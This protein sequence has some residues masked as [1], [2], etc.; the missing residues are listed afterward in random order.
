MTI[1][2]IYVDG[3]AINNENPNVPTLGGVGIGVWVQGQEGTHVYWNVHNDEVNDLVVT[4]P[5]GNIEVPVNLALGVTTNNTTEL[6][7]IYGALEMIRLSNWEKQ[8]DTY[9][10]HGD[11]EYAGKLVF[12]T[13]RAKANK[14]LVAK[15]K[16]LLNDVRELGI[17]VTWKH[18]RAHADNQYNNYVDYLAKS[19]AYNVP[20]TEILTFSQFDNP[21]AA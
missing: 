7:A 14:E 10:I 6:A 2:N 17:D 3:S 13:W 19:G 21:I 9:I 8:N 1:V 16:S 20:P 5:N 12:G 15:T 18:V 4:I 11:S